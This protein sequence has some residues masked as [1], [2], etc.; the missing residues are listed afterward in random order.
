MRIQLLE[1]RCR[2]GYQVAK[3]NVSPQVFL[4]FLFIFPSCFHILMG[5][6]IVSEKAVIG[7]QLPCL[8]DDK[9]SLIL[10]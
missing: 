2:G 9:P 5:H 10:N 8:I 1:T 7:E 3:R 6:F 4:T